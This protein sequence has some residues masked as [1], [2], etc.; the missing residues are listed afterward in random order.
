MSV[1]LSDLANA[2]VTSIWGR[3][4]GLDQ[5][6]RLLGFTDVRNLSED[7]NTTAATSLA[8]WGTSRLMSTIA[9]TGGA[10]AYTL[11]GLPMGAR[12]HIIQTSSSTGGMVVTASTAY[13]STQQYFLSSATTSTGLSLKGTGA[14]VMLQAISTAIIAVIAQNTAVTTA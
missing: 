14:S 1:T 2:I 10:L 7:I 11:P 6:G 3:R 5:D 13:N 12:K 8:A 9:S 4:L